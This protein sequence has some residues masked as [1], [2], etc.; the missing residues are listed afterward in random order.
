[1]GLATRVRELFRFDR[2]HL[3]AIETQFIAPEIVTRDDVDDRRAKL[4]SIIALDIIP[5]LTRLHSHTP[6]DL[7]IAELH[8]NEAQISE[9]AHIVLGAE[10]DTSAAY[11]SALREQGL[12]MDALFVELLEPTARMLGEM[13]ERDEC[14]FIDVTLGVAR[15]Q[16]L[17]SIFNETYQHPALT[18]RRRVLMAT[19]PGDE[20]HFGATMIEEILIA[21]RWS[22]DSEHHATIDE[23]AD[24]VSRQWY[25]VVGLALGGSQWIDNMAATIA[26]IRRHSKNPAVRIMVG[27]PVI[28]ADPLLA[29]RLGADAT[30]VN[31]TSA[32]LVAQKLFDEGVL[33]NWGKRQN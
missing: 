14:D 18:D 13:W 12:S 26:A 24:A 16:K 8:P 6:I 28:N 10:S 7:I 22:V 30:A 20:H 21:S 3:N 17:L 5:H 31:A 1:M 15:L 27:G 19:T 11:I 23:I 29:H 9:L 33:S 32:V 4:A 2:G 25:P